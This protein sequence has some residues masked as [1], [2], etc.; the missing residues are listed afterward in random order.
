MKIYFVLIDY[1][2]S[3]IAVLPKVLYKFNAIP[4]KIPM[5]YFLQKQNNPS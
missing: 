5:K 2:Y 3:Q 4:T 1:W